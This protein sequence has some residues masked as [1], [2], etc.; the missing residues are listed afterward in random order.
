MA[1]TRTHQFLLRQG[2]NLFPSSLVLVKANTS[3]TVDNDEELMLSLRDAVTAWAR[4]TEEG[5][6]LYDSGDVNAGH[7]IGENLDQII[8]HSPSINSLS[9][10]I[11]EVDSEWVFDTDLCDGIEEDSYES[12]S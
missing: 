6:A 11:L 3:L 9:L 7:L 1:T 12:A 2:G 4:K 10:E 5:R 8:S